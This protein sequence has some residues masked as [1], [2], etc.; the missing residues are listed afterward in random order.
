MALNVVVA[1]VVD[2]V[3]LEVPHQ[4][5]VLVAAVLAHAEVLFESLA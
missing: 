3:P 5:E 2:E 1:P 4:P